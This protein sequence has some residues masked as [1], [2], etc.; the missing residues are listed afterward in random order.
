MTEEELAEKRKVA[1]AEQDSSDGE[2]E[3][4]EVEEGS[5]PPALQKAI[6]A[7][8]KKGGDEEE[9]DEDAD[10]D[11]EEDEVEE[12][13]DFERGQKSQAQNRRIGREIYSSDKTKLESANSRN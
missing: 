1:A 9:V 13:Q 5:L 3:E 7:K 6:D 10:E 11:A 2:V 4:G 12:S 8:K